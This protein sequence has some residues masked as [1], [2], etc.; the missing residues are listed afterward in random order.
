VRRAR[1]PWKDSRPFPFGRLGA[2][3]TALAGL[4]TTVGVV[5]ALVGGDDPWNERADAA[6]VHQFDR[7]EAELAAQR[8]PVAAAAEI[9]QG[10]VR[11]VK[12]LEGI[13]PPAK[14]ELQWRPI[15]N[16]A[17][18]LAEVWGMAANSADRDPAGTLGYYRNPPNGL[19]GDLQHIRSSSRQLGLEVCK[20]RD[21][22]DVERLAIDA[23]LRR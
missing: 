1:S 15:V 13:H 12:E 9:W 7:L 11:F 21:L 17:A 2:V 3:I 23:Q 8:P 5:V 20:S 18:D 10:H 6:C 16:S 22:F 14:F 19:L 4:A